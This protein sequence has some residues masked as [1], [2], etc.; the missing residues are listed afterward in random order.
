MYIIVGLGNPGKEYDTTRH[1]VG[2]YMLD[3]FA[4][5]NAIEISKKKFKGLLGQVKINGEDV[6]LLKPQTYMNLSGESLS[7]I[8]TYYKIPSENI[9]VIYDDIDINFEEIRY[10]ES[11][12]AGTHNGMKSIIQHIKTNE[13]KRIRIGI[14]NEKD[15]RQDLSSYVLGNFSKEEQELLKDKVYKKVKDKIFDIVK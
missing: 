1:N 6:I 5:E 9:V 3:I 14:N 10:R 8:V 2:F 12:S 4:K 7:E 11:G 15:K 13:F